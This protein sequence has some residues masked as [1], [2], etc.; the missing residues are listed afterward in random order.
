MIVMIDKIVNVKSES[1]SSEED[2][3]D[4]HEK[5]YKVEEPVTSEEDSDENGCKV[6]EPVSLDEENDDPDEMEDKDDIRMNPAERHLVK[7]RKEFNEEGDNFKN[8]AA[9]DENENPVGEGDITEGKIRGS[10][11]GLTKR[12]VRSSD[13]EADSSK[14]DE[15]RRSMLQRLQP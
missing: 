12:K 10:D 15:V 9:N 8:N 1:S 2:N 4:S 3:D 13:L 14:R 5:G 11:N 7:E 6:E